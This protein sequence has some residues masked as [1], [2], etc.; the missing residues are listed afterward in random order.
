MTISYKKL[1]HLLIDKG[2]SKSALKRLWYH[3][4]LHFE[5]KSKRTCKYQ[6]FAKNLQC[7]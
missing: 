3:V 2:M 4:A 6:S 1:W 7:I 5:V